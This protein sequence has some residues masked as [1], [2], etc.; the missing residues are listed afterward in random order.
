MK[1]IKLLSVLPF[2]FLAIS[3]N[4]DDNNNRNNPIVGNWRMTE[5]L[6]DPG[7]GSGTFTPVETGK[8]INFY[9]DGTLTSNGN[10][11]DMSISANNATTG[12]YSANE[13]TLD[14]GCF[15]EFARTYTVSG[16][17]LIISYP[18][19]EACKAKFVRL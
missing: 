12:V 7:N 2:I 17:T 4:D 10:I 9:S 15:G 16:N 13:N 1:I 14:A 3:C 8:T 18:C 6:A 5:I 19:T 11:C